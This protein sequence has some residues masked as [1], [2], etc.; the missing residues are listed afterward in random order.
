MKGCTLNT[1]NIGGEV[2][3]YTSAYQRFGL[4]LNIDCPRGVLKLLGVEITTF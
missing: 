2:I 4:A 1:R 3:R